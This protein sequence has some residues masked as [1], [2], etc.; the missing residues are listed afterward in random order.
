MNRLTLHLIDLGVSTAAVG[1]TLLI[2]LQ[3]VG[4]F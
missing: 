2:G 1:L 3:L 4:A